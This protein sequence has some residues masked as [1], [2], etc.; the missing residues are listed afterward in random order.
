MSDDNDDFEANKREITAQEDWYRERHHSTKLSLY[1]GFF[2]FEG[3]TLA[4]AAILASRVGAQPV[5]VAVLVL[6]LLSCLILFLQYYWLLTFYDR[7][8]YSKVR[9]RSPADQE[10]YDADVEDARKYFERRRWPRRIGDK[11]LFFFAVAEIILLGYA[12]TRR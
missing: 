1:S 2:A 10:R 8:G 5:V 3:L 6:A 4:A 11:L 12:A 7:M 9:L